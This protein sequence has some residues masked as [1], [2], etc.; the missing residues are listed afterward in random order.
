MAESKTQE[1]IALY[2]D[3][4]VEKEDA[5]KLTKQMR[6]D[7]SRI[8]YHR[9]GGKYIYGVE[10]NCEPGFSRGYQKNYV[11]A[12]SNENKADIRGTRC[13]IPGKRS[14]TKKCPE[15]KSCEGCPNRDNKPVTISIEHSLE[16]HGYDEFGSANEMT[17]QERYEFREILMQAHKRKPAEVSAFVMRHYGYSDREIQDKLKVTDRTVRRYINAASD[18]IRDI[19][20][21]L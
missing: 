15:S 6:L 21:G 18:L 16:N 11:S 5:V 3:E 9:I 4:T 8:V 13:D 12:R 10:M 19:W 7:P 17:D 14:C 2:F 1:R 20:L